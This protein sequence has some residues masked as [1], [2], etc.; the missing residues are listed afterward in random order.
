VLDTK[1]PKYLEMAQRHISLSPG[2][3]LVGTGWRSALPRLE[4]EM[5]EQPP[6][7]ARVRDA[8]SIHGTA[9]HGERFCEVWEATRR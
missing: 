3:S 4:S 8:A 1:S 9:V 6:L 5:E 2:S 7:L